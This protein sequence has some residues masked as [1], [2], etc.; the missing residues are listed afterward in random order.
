M[1]YD[2]LRQSLYRVCDDLDT[3]EPWLRELVESTIELQ[4]VSHS[5]ER[6]NLER[7]VAL[8]SVQYLQQLHTR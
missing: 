4:K 8:K 5:M 2:V 6:P 1:S 7:G 3:R